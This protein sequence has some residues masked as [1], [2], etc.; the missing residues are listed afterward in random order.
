[1]MP[2]SQI[3]MVVFK[4]GTP[5]GR[6]TLEVCGKFERRQG[7]APA[8]TKGQVF[9]VVRQG[10]FVAALHGPTKDDTRWELPLTLE[11]GQRLRLDQPVVV[12]G[13]LVLPREDPAGLGIVSWVQEVPETK[14]QTSRQPAPPNPPADLS[15]TTVGDGHSGGLTSRD[16]VA[17]SLAI[18]QAPAASGEPLSWRQ[19]VEVVQ[20]KQPGAPLDGG[21]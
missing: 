6:A 20:V 8:P 1:M 7:D 14:I 10:D 19:Q 16:S 21:G 17:S 15:G 2:M 11:P 4:D 18:H 3:D 13:A 5:P 9:V 12:S